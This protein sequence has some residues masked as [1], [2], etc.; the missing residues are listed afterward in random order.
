[1]LRTLLHFVPLATC[2]ML[3][4]SLARAQAVSGL[5]PGAHVRIVATALGTD[6]RKAHVVALRNDEI[7][8]R[9]DGSGDVITVARDQLTAVD[10]SGGRRGWGRRGMA[11]GALTAVVT[12]A[13]LAL[14]YNPATCAGASYYCETKIDVLL[15]GSVYLG[16]PGVMLGGLIGLLTRTE[17][18]VKLPP[19]AWTSRVSLSVPN[20]RTA[21]VHITF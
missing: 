4:P 1:M 18:W 13:A 11:V 9:M 5:N 10:Y 14:T 12:S 2:M 19:G 6:R 16:I 7:D 21:G 20:V 8:F 17:R 3:S 15:G